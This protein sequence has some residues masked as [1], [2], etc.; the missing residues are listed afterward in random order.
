[1]I[2]V[3]AYALLPHNP[4]TATSL[5]TLPFGFGEAP[6]NL[7]YGVIYL[8]LIVLMIAFCTAH[9]QQLMAQELAQRLLNTFSGEAGEV[10]GMPARNFF[11]LIRKPSLNRVA[12]LVQLFRRLFISGPK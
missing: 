8:L 11:D 1:M 5:I 6:P 4:D 7:F 10:G 3:E 9:A 12:P 2:T